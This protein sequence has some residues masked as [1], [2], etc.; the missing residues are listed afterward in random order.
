M[1]SRSTLLFLLALALGACATSKP[2]ADVGPPPPPPPPTFGPV[3]E[4]SALVGTWSHDHGRIRI[5]FRADGG[6]RQQLPGVDK[7]GRWTL[8]GDTLGVVFEHNGK[9]LDEAYKVT[10]AQDGRTLLF[11][12]PDPLRLTR[13]SDA[14]ESP[15]T[16]LDN[17]RPTALGE[18]PAQITL[19]PGWKLNA[20]GPRLIDVVNNGATKVVKCIFV[21]EEKAVLFNQNPDAALRFIGQQMGAKT[22]PPGAKVSV[23]RAPEKKQA[24]G[25]AVPGTVTVVFEMNG[26]RVE[27]VAFWAGT[28]QKVDA[29]IV[30]L[31]V[32]DDVN[33][34]PAVVATLKS[35]APSAPTST[36]NT[37]H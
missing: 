13:E 26:E 19:P 37:A 12:D 15:W 36:S 33:M 20:A 14:I 23:V 29:I 32:K 2:A 25:I 11:G 34:L 10:I 18:H 7:R 24:F 22:P 35:T 27:T 5:Q 6:F 17:G 8:D 9:E 31:G 3:Q 4:A 1:A 28:F 16:L 30:V 21:P